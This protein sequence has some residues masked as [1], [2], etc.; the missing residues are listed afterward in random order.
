LAGKLEKTC[1][2][3]VMYKKEGACVVLET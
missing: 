1:G 2:L 3:E